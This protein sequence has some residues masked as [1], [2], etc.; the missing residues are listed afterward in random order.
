MNKSALKRFATEM[1]LEL[2]GLV[3]TKLEYLLGLGND[4][5][6]ELKDEQNN[7]RRI[8]SRCSVDDV[9]DKTN[10]EEL[11]EEVAYTWFNR[12]IALRFM[13]VNEIT[14]ESIISPLEGQTLPELFNSAKSGEINDELKLD[15]KKFYDIIDGKIPSNN[16]DNEAYKML[17]I[18]TC[19][20]YS[21]LMPFMFEAISDY[22]ELLLPEDM[23]SSNSIRSKVVEA[24]SSEDSKDVEIIGWLYQF[25]INE[26]KDEVIQA[27]K[28]YKT[29][30]IPFASQLFT[31]DWL[32]Q[33]ITDNTLGQLWMENNPNSSL[34]ESMQYYVA[35]D[36]VSDKKLLPEEIKIFDPCC[37]SGHILTYAF[38]LL[39]KIY[40]EEGYNKSE[41]PTL[42]LEN[43]LYG[44]DID[45][46]AM[47]LANFALT[48]KARLYH[49][50]FFRKIVKPNII[51]L[52]E[53]GDERF[54]G[55]KNF[56]S[57]VRVEDSETFNDGIFSQTS[58]EYKLQIQMLT[59]KFD[60]IITNPPY[61]NSLYM[62]AEIK[63]FVAY[64]YPKTKSD[65]FACFMERIPEMTKKNGYM[66]FV[67]PYGWMFTKYYELLR[68]D[69]LKNTT[70]TNLVQLEYNAFGPAVVP[71]CSFTLKNAQTLE[72]GNY[73]KLSNFK[74]SENQPIKTL[75]AI[76]EDVDYIYNVKQ[77]NFSKIPGIPIA[78]WISKKNIEIFEQ[79]IKFND[80]TV[81]KSGKPS[82]GK[83][84]LWYKFWQECELK[85]ISLSTDSYKNINTKFVPLNKG[86]AFRRWYG[87]NE[88]ITD[89][90]FCY[91]D[92]FLF[93]S[94]LT[95]SD[96]S[97]GNFSLRYKNKGI[98]SNNVGKMTFPINKEDILELIALL[99]TQLI[100]NYLD[101]LIP[102]MH[103][104]T[105]Y[106]GQLP[107]IFSKSKDI[108]NKIRI[109]TQQ[110]IDISKEEWDSRETSWNFTTNELI[111][112][113][114]DTKIETAYT[115]Y[116]N[117]WKE[118]HDTLHQNEEE[119]NRLFIDIYGLQDELTPDVEQKDIT[120]LKN[121]TKI[122][123][124]ALVFQA[125]E[126]MKQFISYGVGVMFG[127]Y[128][129]DSDGLLI[130]NMAQ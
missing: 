37:G 75:Q 73:I 52:E 85:K 69:I 99:N 121:E 54:V 105:L 71:V 83:N 7:I 86:G 56:G 118:Q 16:P 77:E 101:L 96:I 66:G 30:E 44:C 50:R 93:E 68:K 4:V 57:L 109:L 130:A 103:F 104:D 125:D 119:L 38:D 27:K 88:Y 127:R 23:L 115:D 3:S 91:E 29:S 106:I 43:N 87:N 61:I 21:R 123:D 26:K 18:A 129:L 55:I 117:Y 45:K 107:I 92:D 58:K 124:G 6:V 90:A 126:I 59:D 62:N 25:Y 10:K 81:M 76:N 12:L 128:S 40:E 80:I 89:V 100:N 110:N 17:F 60:C 122:I 2:M 34:K 9:I 8:T 53:Y 78:Y 116:C 24:M 108:K 15:R 114:S 63:S 22:T 42:I 47:V 19:N 1:R 28:K 39:T 20:N 36:T 97:S 112:H 5:P 84:D 31:P 70:I 13:D 11:I 14:E 120:I 46:R 32:V 94:G 72:N 67:T 41:I 65:L 35:R 49:K 102:T 98:V 33:Y 113:K 48:M 82:Y 74:G 51:E 111:K 95:W 64:N 79:N